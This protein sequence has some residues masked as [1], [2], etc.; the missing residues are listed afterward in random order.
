MSTPAR[1]YVGTYAKYNDG[2]IEGA[3][4]DLEDFRNKNEFEADVCRSWFSERLGLQQQRVKRNQR[5]YRN[6]S[7]R[8]LIVLL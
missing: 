7:H 4:L 1:I 8:R 3:W 5:V 2:S 6:T